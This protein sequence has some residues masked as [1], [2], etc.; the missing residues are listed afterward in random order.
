MSVN[1]VK[2]KDLMVPLAEYNTAKGGET[3]QEMFERLE[4]ELP[5]GMER[6]HRD[7]LVV[8]DDGDLI[9]KVTVHDVIMA[10]EPSYAKLDDNGHNKALTGSYVKKIYREYD[11]WSEPLHDL[12]Q[13]GAALKVAQVMHPPSEAE[14]I[15]AEEEIDLALH[16]FV[17]GV[18]QPL[19][20]MD[21]KRIVGVLRLGDVFDHIREVMKTCKL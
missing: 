13:K 20:V 9:G 17:M 18:H 10:M 21:G 3:L 19:M 15:Q 12:C 4:G 11:L 1:P 16:M 5:E 8:N 2:V 14:Y 7:V 6:P